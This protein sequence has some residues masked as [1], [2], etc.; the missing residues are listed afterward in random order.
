MLTATDLAQL[1]SKGISEQ[2]VQQQIKNFQQGFP[3]MKLQ[4]AAPVG[5]GIIRLTSEQIEAYIKYYRDHLEGTSVV[6]FV[7]ASGAA[8]RMFK[9]FF[10]LLQAPD[11]GDQFPKAVEALD[12]V[13]DFAF[14]DQLHS[15]MASQ[16]I[17]LEQQLQNGDF[18]AVLDYILG[19]KGLNYGFLPKGLLAFHKYNGSYRVPMEEHLVEAAHYGKNTDGSS[20]LHFTVSPQHL[21]LFKKLEESVKGKYEQQFGVSYK[22][23]YS[24]QKPSTDTIAVDLDNEPFRNDDGTLLFRPGGHGALLENLNEIDGD[25]IFIKNIDNVVPDHLKEETYRYK[26][27]LGGLLLQVRR[28]VFDLLKR[29]VAGDDMAVSAA[30]AYLKD[31]L[32]VQPPVGR[33]IDQNYLISKLNRPIRVCGMV[34]NEG[35]P[36]GGPFWTLGSDGTTSLQIVETSQVDPD[37]DQQQGIVQ[38][39]T[40]FN[41]VDLVCS[42]RDYHGNKFNLLKY[43]DPNTG[44]IS[45]KSKDGRELKALELPGL[46]NG[47][48]ADWNTIFVEVPAVTFNP[49]KTVNDLLRDEHQPQG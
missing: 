21:S 35:E 7:P 42:T 3:Y 1:E 32:N 41:P 29:V 49:V 8:S 11:Q 6:K 17:D 27:A 18:E 26:A 20:K 30:A 5:D 44:F 23:S 14:Y 46:W 39:S 31:T 12:R 45:Q 28:E 37:D 38:K 25:L 22:I 19:E 34:I 36:G 2:Q 48:M 9:D 10:G 16:G 33:R 4:R 24:E 47:S 13:K 15:T 40:H 43:R